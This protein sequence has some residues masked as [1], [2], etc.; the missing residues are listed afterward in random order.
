MVVVVVVV[1]GVQ[2][3]L[4]FQFWKLQDWLFQLV[5]ISWKPEEVGSNIHPGKKVQAIKEE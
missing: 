2:L 1:L 4:H 3:L 5:C